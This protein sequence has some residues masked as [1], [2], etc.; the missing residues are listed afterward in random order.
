MPL[1]VHRNL[2][3]TLQISL[4]WSAQLP[5]RAFSP[6]FTNSKHMQNSQKDLILVNHDNLSIHQASMTS[7]L[8]YTTVKSG[9]QLG[10]VI[11]SAWQHSEGSMTSL[12]SCTLFT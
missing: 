7:S 8:S 6:C 4:L 12:T 11:S 5:I 2:T 3:S 10:D 9:H 1:K